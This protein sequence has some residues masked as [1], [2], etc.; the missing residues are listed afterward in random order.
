M[1]KVILVL[2]DEKGKAVEYKQVGVKA[3]ILKE[4]MMFSMKAEKGE[5]DGGEYEMINE[6]VE[7]VA[8]VFQDP[9][10]TADAIYDGLYAHE[11]FPTLQGVLEQVM[12]G[13]YSDEEIKEG[14]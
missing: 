9:K 5:F 14:K 12:G 10:V 6:M 4:I 11:L 13:L 8:K 1:Q 3:R 2:E 7:L